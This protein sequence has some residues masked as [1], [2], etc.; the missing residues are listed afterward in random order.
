MEEHHL[1]KEYTPGSSKLYITISNYS[2]LSHHSIKTNPN[3]LYISLLSG[4]ERGEM[5]MLTTTATVQT[6]H[7]LIVKLRRSTQMC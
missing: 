6:L 7:L 2:S 4:N 3:D 1:L 5:M